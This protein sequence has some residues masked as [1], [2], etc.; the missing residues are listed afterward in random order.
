MGGAHQGERGERGL[1]HKLQAPASI[2]TE[3]GVP[4]ISVTRPA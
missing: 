3:V 2:A 1:I 4:P